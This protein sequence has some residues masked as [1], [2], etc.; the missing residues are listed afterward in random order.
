[1]RPSA[2]GALSHRNFRLFFVGQIVSLTGTWMQSVA[3]GWLVLLLTDSPF[4]VGLVAALGSLGVLVFTLY[5]GVVADRSD[6]RRT[7]IVTQTLQMIQALTLAAL[8][9]SGHVTPAAVLVLAAVLGVV[10]AFDIPTRQAFL[11]DMVGKDDL[12]NAIALNTSAFNASRI[13]GPVVAGLV[14]TAAGGGTTGTAWCFTL[15]GVS[16][17][18]V[19]V[20][21]LRMRLPAFV[22][23]AVARSAWASFREVL[24]YLGGDRR[25]ATLVALTALVSLFGFPFLA[26][27]PVF[28]RDVLSTDARGYGVLMASVGVGALSGALGVALLSRR[29]RPGPVQLAAGTAF[30]LAVAGMAWSRSLGLA[31]LLL[32][33]VG[34]FMIVNNALTNTMLQTGVPDALRGRLMGFYSFVFVGMAPVGAFLGGAVAERFGV[35]VAV[36]AGGLLCAAAVALAGWRVRELRQAG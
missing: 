26:L 18:A 19:I 10:S 30:G 31:A 11:V 25:A 12:M 34:C 32:V 21:L 5:A 6:K 24:G 33:A 29:L 8:V 16:Y 13:V 17:L 27:M 36:S 28:A 9:W 20:G 23:P 15:N 1:V 14:M 35:S 22:P 7:I 3:Q 4:Y 2:F